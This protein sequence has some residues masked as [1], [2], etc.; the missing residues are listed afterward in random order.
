MNE[1]EKRPFPEDGVATTRTRAFAESPPDV[2][3]APPPLA[4]APAAP[5]SED[6]GDEDIAAAIDGLITPTGAFQAPTPEERLAYERQTEAELKEMFSNIV[7]EFLQPVGLSLHTLS[8]Y[9]ARAGEGAEKSRIIHGTIDACIGALRPLIKA[10]E[11]IRYHDIVD[12]LRAI[13]RPLT[14]MQGGKRKSLTERDTKNLMRDFNELDR[15]IRQS[16]SAPTDGVKDGGGERA[17]TAEASGLRLSDVLPHFKTV[18]P[19]DVQKLYAA[20]IT[21]L[22][23]LG[24]ASAQEIAQA[25]GVPVG[26]A[27]RIKSCAFAALMQPP[28]GGAPNGVRRAA[29]PESAAFDY[30]DAADDTAGLAS[31]SLGGRDMYFPDDDEP[32]DERER[33]INTLDVMQK[34]IASYG[35]SATRLNVELQRTHRALLRLRAERERLRGEVEFHRDELRRMLESGGGNSEVTQS[36]VAR[37]KGLSQELRQ[38]SEIV[39][40]AMKKM[41]IIYGQM[42]DAIRDIRDLEIEMADLRRKRRAPRSRGRND[43]EPAAG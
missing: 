28:P 27:E 42:E 10:S 43:G 39:L 26:V 34:E 9:V 33:V 29:A 30:D 40:S 35:Q 20:G 2:P 18:D 17:V 11:T 24:A 31:G 21:R 25:A 14:E 1:R 4:V 37:H 8:D 7:W 19:A 32:F 5:R 16:L 22:A 38:V 41:D 13:E 6:A 15:L 12:V 3:D 36:A 23:E